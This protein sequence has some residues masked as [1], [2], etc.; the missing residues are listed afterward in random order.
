MSKQI[1]NPNDWA[2]SWVQS[3]A[4]AQTNYT[5]GIQ[6]VTDNPLAKAAN[7]S[8]KYLAGVNAAVSSGSYQRGLL[9]VPFDQW[10]KSATD[11]ASRISTGFQ[12]S[13]SK[14]TSY[15]QKAASVYSNLQ[16]Q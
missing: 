13:K 8:D 14:Y 5:K 11:K 1:K 9:S 12:A 16:S 6:S 4:T 15:A 3:G 7:S 2:N 10:K